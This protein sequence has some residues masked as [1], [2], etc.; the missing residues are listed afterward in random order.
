MEIEMRG[1][2]RTYDR[3]LNTHTCLSNYHSST[4]TFTAYIYDSLYS[5]ASVVNGLIWTFDGGRCRQ[6]NYPLWI[7]QFYVPL[8]DCPEPTVTYVTVSE[9]KTL[10]H[11]TYWQSNHIRS[12]AAFLSHLRE[13]TTVTGYVY[14]YS[15]NLLHCSKL[16][17]GSSI[18]E[19]QTI[20]R[21]VRFYICT[22][23]LLQYKY[24]AFPPVGP[25]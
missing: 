16:F 15:F 18:D 13:S 24:M 3:T 8:C 21:T 25:W 1:F 9:A 5:N 12:T 22:C 17:T 23:Y 14:I 20:N 6:Y 10:S 7:E 11:V 19:N 2:H 4:L